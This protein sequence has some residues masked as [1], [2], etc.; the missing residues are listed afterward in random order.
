MYTHTHTPFFKT[1]FFLFFNRGKGSWL[2]NH[3]SRLAQ[4]RP[5][6]I[7]HFL[8]EELVTRRQL[9]VGVVGP[10]CVAPLY[11]TVLVSKWRK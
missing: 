8:W 11:L 7:P 3:D 5:H 6:H 9:C 2:Q 4:A 1:C 10:G